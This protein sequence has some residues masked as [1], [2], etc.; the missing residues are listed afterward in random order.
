MAQIVTTP[1]DINNFETKNRVWIIDPPIRFHVRYKRRAKEYEARGSGVYRWT[2]VHAETM[3]E[4]IYY[5]KTSTLMELWE[6]GVYNDGNL[7]YPEDQ[8]MNLRRRVAVTIE[9]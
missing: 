5:I 7:D 2:Y 4:L 1:L 9:K 8:V 3:D 6:D